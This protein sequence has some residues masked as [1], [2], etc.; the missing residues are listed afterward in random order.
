MTAGLGMTVLLLLS[1]AETPPEAFPVHPLPV[2][3]V[4]AAALCAAVL[5]AL[6][7]TPYPL[8]RGRAPWPAL[9][10]ASIAGVLVLAAVV[11][12]VALAA[13]GD[14]SLGLV[15]GMPLAALSAVAAVPM[16]EGIVRARD[17][18]RT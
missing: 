1:S 4:A 8:G 7:A 13:A 16:T 9:W 2:P 10:G 11:V 15:F 3:A 5:A 18:A 14:A 6:G 17:R 12:A